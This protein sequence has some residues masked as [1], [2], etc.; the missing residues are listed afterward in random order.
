MRI[1]RFLLPLALA[2]G[3]HAQTSFYTYNWPGAL[4]AFQT[5]SGNPLILYSHSV[6]DDG[7]GP[8]V[9]LVYTGTVP[10]SSSDYSITTGVNSYIATNGS[11]VSTF[12]PTIYHF[13]RDN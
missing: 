13:L 3:L 11:Y 1:L 10:G 8:P 4:G 5:V 7:S 12:V 2:L 9:H 6:T